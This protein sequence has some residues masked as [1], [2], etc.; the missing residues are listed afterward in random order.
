[1]EEREDYSALLAQG[2]IRP[3]QLELMLMDADGSNKR[4]LTDNGAANF[5]PFLH[6]DNDTIIFCSN[7][8]DPDGFAFNLYTYSLSTGKTEQVTFHEDFD[9]FPMFSPCGKYLVWCS[10]RNNSQPRET[11]VFIAEWV[12]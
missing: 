3:G 8:E 10:N 9:G 2:L 11:N 6:P 12:P 4:Q 7:I 1:E 5:A